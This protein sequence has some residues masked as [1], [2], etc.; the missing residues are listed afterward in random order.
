MTIETEN[1]S[2]ALLTWGMRHRNREFHTNR[3]DF[4]EWYESTII[5][6][7]DLPGIAEAHRIDEYYAIIFPYLIE[8]GYKQD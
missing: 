4:W 5:K 1:L 8:K 6:L 7:Q 3:A 2:E